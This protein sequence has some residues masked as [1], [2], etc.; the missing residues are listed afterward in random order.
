MD[1]ISN[2][3]LSVVNRLCTRLGPVTALLDVIVKRIAPNATAHAACPHFFYS[4][5]CSSPTCGAI[6]RG[7]ADYMQW[8][9]RSW[10]DDGNCAHAYQC[11]DCVYC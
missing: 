7:G 10:T 8:Q 6:C 1:T 4:T 9:Y 11:Q 3:L 2:D 5:P